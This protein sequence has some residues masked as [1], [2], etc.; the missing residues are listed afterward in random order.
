MQTE[1]STCT[2]DSITLWPTALK[3]DGGGRTS[4]A[5]IQFSSSPRGPSASLR[6]LATSILD[7]SALEGAE[8][9][10][11]SVQNFDVPAAT[12]TAMAPPKTK[13]RLFAYIDLHGHASKRGNFIFLLI[14]NFM[15]ILN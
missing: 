1:E 14:Q 10:D 7:G 12:S 8:E 13:S 2:E 6:P 11:I 5:G 15:N 9:A 3:Q 4:F